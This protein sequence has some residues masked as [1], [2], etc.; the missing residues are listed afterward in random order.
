MINEIYK[1]LTKEQ[2]RLLSYAFDNKISQL[3]ELPGR[4]FIGVNLSPTEY[5]IVEETKN[6]WFV[7]YFK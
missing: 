3:V 7:G 1:T 6:N 2:Q 5:M 4:R